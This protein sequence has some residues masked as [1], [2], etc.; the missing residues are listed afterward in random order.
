MRYSAPPGP[1]GKRGQ[2]RV[3]GRT[4]KESRENYVTG[5]G[6]IQAG[7]LADDRRTK[8]ADYLDRRCGS[9]G[10]QAAR[11]YSLIKPPRTGFRWIR[12]RSRSVTVMRLP[13]CSPSGTRWAMSW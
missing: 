10:Y 9:S 6:D 2:P 5:M 7:R 13:S 1:G 8:F 4:A 11:A 12:W 3:Y